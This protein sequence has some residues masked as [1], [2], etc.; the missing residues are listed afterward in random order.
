MARPRKFNEQDVM[1][2]VR[3]KFNETGYHGTS[4]DDLSRATGLSKGSLYGAFGDKE[5]LF[6]RV[7]EEYCARSDEGAA[8]RLEGPEDQ[9]LDRLRS[10]LQASESYQGRRGCLL[11]KTTAELSWENDAIAARSLAAYE[12][13]LDSCRQLIEQAQRAGHV[14]PSADAEVLGGLILTTHRGLEALAK[15]GVDTKTRNRIADAAIDNI[16]LTVS[17]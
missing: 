15:A 5:A 1:A 2:A 10:W 6:R 12:T 16:A 17:S 4:V 9:A 7:F 11:A 13:L 8:A 3:W 14:D